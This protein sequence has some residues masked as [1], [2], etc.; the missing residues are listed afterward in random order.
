MNK[1]IIVEYKQALKELTSRFHS[2][3]NEKLEV[4]INCNKTGKF[5][6]VDISLKE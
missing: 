3:V 2:K 6:K 5:I 1:R 4:T